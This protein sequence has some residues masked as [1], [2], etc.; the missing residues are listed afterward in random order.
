MPLEKSY[1]TLFPGILVS[2]AASCIV[3]QCWKRQCQDQSMIWDVEAVNEGRGR[4]TQL[5][6]WA[7][8]CRRRYNCQKISQHIDILFTESSMLIRLCWLMNSY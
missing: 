1:K 4:M 2:A 7:S 3:M 8:H 6:C 5:A